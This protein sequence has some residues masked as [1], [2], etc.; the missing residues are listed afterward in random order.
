MKTFE[1]FLH[2]IH[3]DTFCVYWLFYL[4]Y[5]FTAA[6][7]GRKALTAQQPFK[8]WLLI[9]GAIGLVLGIF[10]PLFTIIPFLWLW[11]TVIVSLFRKRDQQYYNIAYCSLIPLLLIIMNRTYGII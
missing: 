2:L 10:I 6:W 3:N 11:P 1:H 8:G 4:G 5:I 7:L 9:S